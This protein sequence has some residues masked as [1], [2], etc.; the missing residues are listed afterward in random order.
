MFFTQIFIY[1]NNNKNIYMLI[2]KKRFILI[3][4]NSIFCLKN[5]TIFNRVSIEIG[6]T[7]PLP[8]FVFIRSLRTLLPPPQQTIY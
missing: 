7:A 4:R 8:L 1:D 2:Y 6:L 5:Q 3:T